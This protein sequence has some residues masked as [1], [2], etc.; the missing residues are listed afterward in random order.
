MWGGIVMAG[1]SGTTILNGGTGSDNLVGGSGD[2][3]LDGGAGNDTLNG[4]SGSDTLDGGA[5]IDRVL[6]GSGADTL[7]YKAFENQWLSG[8]SYSSGAVSG[9]TYMGT[10][11]GT[12]YSGYDYYDGG[13]GSSK[14]GTQNVADVDKLQI[15]LSP[16]QL[17]DAAI[18]AEIDYVQN[19]WIPAQKNANTGQTGPAIYQFKTINLQ[20]SQVETID[21]RNFNGSTDIIGPKLISVTM[22]D[23]ALKIGDTSTVTVTFSEAVTF[24]NS[25]V[26]VE[27]GTLSTFT[28]SPDG[29]VWTATFTPTANIEDSSNVVTVGPNYTD[30]AGNAGT[31]GTSANYAIDTKAPTLSITDDEAAAVAN[32]AGGAVV[33]TF[34]FSEDVTGFTTDDITVTGGTAGTFTAIDGH[35]YTLSVTPD[36]NNQAG[37]IGVSVANGAATDG[38]GNPIIGSSASQNYDT[39]NPTV[40]DV[41]VSDALI[42]DNDAGSIFTVTVTFSEAMDQSVDPTLS[43]APA[44][45]ATLTPGSGGWVNATT[46][47]AHYAVADGNVDH[48]SVTIDV[49]GA[50]DLAGNLQDDYAP[51]SEFAVDTL[52]PTVT[53]GFAGTAL[54]DGTASSQVNFVFSEAPVGFAQGDISAS[55][56]AISNLVMDDATHYHATFTADDGFSG[57]GSVTVDAA[58]F[59]DAALNGNAA[60]TPA[61]I[62]IDTLNPTLVSVTMSDTALKI[63]D[64]ST[65]TVAFSEAVTGFDNSDVTVEHG[66]LSTFTS[67][68]G[69]VWTA[70]FTP[71]A[72]IEDSSNV[73]T[74]GPNYTDLAG[75]AGSGGTSAN[76]A[77][78]TKAPTLSI[79]DDE[80]AAVANNAGG[81]VVFTFTFSEN[82]TGF[83]ASDITV[84]GGTAGTFTAVNGHSYTLSV[85]PNADSQ[86]GTIAVSVADGAATDL[87]G[88]AVTG[89]SASQNYDTLNPTVTV[90]F[91]GTAL[92]D[93]T[94]SSQVNFVFSEAPVGFAQ[95]DISAS[96]GAISN[97]VMDDAT[98]YHA[99]FTADDGFSGTGSVTVDAARFTD[100]ALNGNAAATPA[101]IDIDTL[102]P[103]LVSVTMSDTAL[104]IGDTSTVTV[105]FSEAVTG[106]D[107]SDV[108]VEHGTLSTFTSLDGKVWTATFT[109]TANIEDSSNVVTVGPNY[110]DLAGNAGSGGTSANYAID[111][112]APTLSITDDEAAAVANNAGGA[113]VFTFT[114]S[115]DV[116]GFTTDDI[117][118]TGGTA[119]TFTAIDGHSYTLSVTPDANNQAGTIAVS[120]ADGAAVDGAGNPIIGSSAS[121]N[122]DTLNPTLAS[123]TMSDSALKIGDT[124]IVTVTFSEAVTGFDNSDVTVEHG[125][126][127]TFTS[128]DGK[129]WT[130]TFTPTANIEDDSNVVTVGSGYTDLAGNA[131]TGGTSAN[132][133]IDTKAPTLSITDDEAAAVANNA[134]GA[135]VFTFTFSENVTGFTASDITVTGGTAGTFTAVNGHSYT[136]SVTPDANN[137]AGTIGV[138]VA[139]GAAM[140]GA[141]NP[142]IGASASQNYD[143]KNPTVAVNIIDAS[144]DNNDPSSQ[145]T[146]TFSETPVG[147][148]SGDISAVGGTISNF[149]STADPLVYTATY[150]KTAG[151]TGTGSVSVGSTL[152]TDAAL[153]PGAPGSDTVAVSSGDTTSPGITSITGLQ[154]NNNQNS[155]LI[156]TFNE[157]MNTSFFD[158][159]K[160]HLA[161]AT[162]TASIVTGTGAWSSNNT[163][164]T[165]EVAKTNGANNGTS[166]TAAIDAGAFKDVAGNLSNA[167][168]ASGL[169]PAGVAGAPIN[170][171]LSSPA[172]QAGD[173]LVTVTH[174]P[175]DWALNGGTRNADGS[176]TV[177]TADPRALSVTTPSTFAGAMVLDVAMSWT[178]ADGAMATM[179][180]ADNVEAYAPGNP[181]FA[182]SGD[183]TLTGS[184][185]AD[186]FV[187]AQPIGADQVHDFD[188]GADRIDLIG[189]AGIGDFS[190]VLAHLAEDASGNAL[191]TLAEGQT[192]TLQGVTAAALTTANFLFDETPVVSNSGV[193]TIGNGAML[194]LSGTIVNSGVISLESTG[195]TTLLQLIQYGTT[196]QGGG[197]VVL[198]DDGGNVISGTLP[199]VTLNN[200]DNIISGAGEIGAGTLTLINGGSI[201]ADGTHGLVLDTGTNMISNSGIIAATGS[202]GLTVVSA[203]DNEGL[204][205]LNSS[206]AVLVGDV[207]GSGDVVL[208]GTAT[209]E[210]GGHVTSDIVVDAGATG[211]ILFDDSI[212]FSGT[213]AGL[214]S[215]DR[216]DLSDLA[217]DAA[218]MLSYAANDTG[219]GGVLTVTS[220]ADV[221]HLTLI[222][223]Y[224][225][226]DFG[227]WSDGHSGTLISFG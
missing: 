162:G 143:T 119:G 133:E 37:T 101:T 212:S 197:H 113:V 224:H 167:A 99:T 128:L 95:G 105:A 55:H 225:A 211:L 87:A 214:D 76:Y 32:N 74:V 149:Q 50:R 4:G 184:A 30:I 208:S 96:H 75:N 5:G 191:L 180:I 161:A 39:K 185:Q 181:I 223:S 9:G 204:I 34:T 148:G 126:L 45:G 33:F 63:G 85:M 140:D 144:L 221:A 19:I 22:S 43:F 201:I 52:N 41:T 109:P 65:V 199:S 20:I 138:S 121:Q 151:F 83:T 215:D 136:L 202:G 93:G 139:N 27:H 173:V 147:F 7:I 71:T 25:D 182:W 81:A 194:P 205:Q 31:G 159:S 207:S 100:A 220:G 131:G 123:V 153:N 198:S 72:N 53:V 28:S 177:L 70:T 12:G 155:K 164:F 80:A 186:I 42:A 120:V 179:H 222:G 134:G 84:T 130:A 11:S 78:D 187:F 51:Q 189:Y 141:G 170:L 68:D 98:H 21:I 176:W 13:S 86:S 107:N 108:T 165:I 114:F 67:L 16:T 219:T 59:T 142:I 150:T 210:F 10:S 24:D 200:V 217:F 132:Y 23:T 124:S 79:T 26:T 227:L 8:S 89:A 137:Q 163:V 106:F 1:A 58:R 169:K 171:G 73:V 129:V 196:L 94:A 3:F 60:A 178:Q 111:T 82:V 127:S 61:T 203:I 97:L 104:K 48:D 118:V 218:T 175:D 103:T 56:G 174:M 62:D 125:T 116:T 18:R 226:E 40:T 54:S 46:Y 213:I 188:I 168:Q 29:K 88:N 36:A 38:A 158:A 122:Y 192:I 57:T 193:M 157:A 135:V 110:T 66:T 90:G 17:A 160:I 152:Y 92:S 183:D 145:V 44:M 15:W 156:I 77:I 91:A 102:N 154:G 206:H 117:T 166:Y 216:V 209:V 35:S 190:G 6:G 49:S 47:Q 112:K 172:D 64:T 115:E 2:D 14:L 195:D 69:K 146:F